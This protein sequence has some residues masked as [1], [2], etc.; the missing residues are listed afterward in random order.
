MVKTLSLGVHHIT[1]LLRFGRAHGSYLPTP[2]YRAPSAAKG[3]GAAGPVRR[4]RKTETLDEIYC[5]TR[6]GVGTVEL[7][8][9]S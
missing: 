7:A 3:Q 1:M 5:I 9:K 4:R 2:S 6:P 8:F